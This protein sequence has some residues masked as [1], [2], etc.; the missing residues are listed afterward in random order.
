MAGK[1]ESDGSPLTL[2]YF[3]ESEEGYFD[4][5]IEIASRITSEQFGLNTGFF[6]AI[7]IV[8]DRRRERKQHST[9]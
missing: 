5:R 4:G 3:S 8:Y 9:L 1:R 7:R 6:W 2:F